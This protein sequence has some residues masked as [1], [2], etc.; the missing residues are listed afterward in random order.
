MFHD[1]VGQFNPESIN[2]W[3]ASIVGLIV[4][5]ATMLLGQFLV[6]RQLGYHPPQPARR[7][8]KPYDPFLFGSHLE[9]RTSL[10]RTGNPVPVLIL[11]P[12][13]PEQPL[14]GWVLDRSVGG[15]CVS[16]PRPFPI[17]AY[18][19]VRAANAADSM[20]AVR[21]KVRH[22]RKLDGRY[23]VGCQYTESYPWSVLLLFG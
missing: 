16:S 10:R 20:P 6:G 18:L 23:A 8:G 3:A 9:K 5:G 19:M 1:L 15:L 21:V 2:L 11:D 22:H 13:A 12:A 7:E 17:D 14:E 4:G